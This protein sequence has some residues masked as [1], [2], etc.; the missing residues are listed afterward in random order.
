MSA[1]KKLFKG[2]R[3]IKLLEETKEKSVSPGKVCPNLS[4]AKINLNSG[5]YL[6]KLRQFFKKNL[7]EFSEKLKEVS[8]KNQGFIN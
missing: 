7:T 6:I 4:P 2:S 8:L 5:I 1:Q 3:Q